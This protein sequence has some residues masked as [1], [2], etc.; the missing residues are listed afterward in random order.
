MLGKLFVAGY[1]TTIFAAL[2]PLLPEGVY[3]ERNRADLSD[4]GWHPAGAVPLDARW[5]LLAAGYLEPTTILEQSAAEIAAHLAVNL[6]S[7]VKACEYVLAHNP[8]ARICLVGSESGIK[9]SYNQTY[10][11]AKAGL[12]RYVETKRLAHP[13]Q[14]L[15]C[16][17]PGMIANSAMT[18]RRADQDNVEARRVAHP[19]RRLLRAGEVARMIHNLLFVDE[20]YTTNV[21]IPMLGRPC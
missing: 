7:P 5:H 21:V 13:D 9:G 2:R 16:V 11:I 17:A 12:H 4:L 3:I 1:S 15:V 14:Q 10:A 8:R 19:K 6:V 18:E 20:G